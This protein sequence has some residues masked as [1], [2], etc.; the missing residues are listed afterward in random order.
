MSTS[1]LPELEGDSIAALSFKLFTQLLQRHSCTFS[2][3]HGFACIELR[4]IVRTLH[5]DARGDWTLVTILQP[6]VYD[7][8]I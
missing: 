4:E 7:L 6:P 2:N 8:E 5:Q 1:V 3:G